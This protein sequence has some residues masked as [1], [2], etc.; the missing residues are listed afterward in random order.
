MTRFQECNRKIEYVLQEGHW[1]ITDIT[2]DKLVHRCD[3]ATLEDRIKK[4]ILRK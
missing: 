1:Y 4:A 2:A 3:M